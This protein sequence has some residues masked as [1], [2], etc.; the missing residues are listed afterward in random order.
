MDG[1][2]SSLNT[3][4]S[5][6]WKMIR[7]EKPGMLQSLGLPR[8][9]HDLATEQQQKQQLGFGGEGNNRIGYMGDIANLA[10]K[11]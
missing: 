6:L 5:K 3:N 9:G 1:I 11:Q 7:N 8:V 2:S 10:Q 4:L